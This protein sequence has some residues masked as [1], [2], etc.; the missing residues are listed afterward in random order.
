MDGSLNPWRAVCEAAVRAHSEADAIR[1]WKISHATEDGPRALFDYRFEHTL[2][3]VKL[4]RWLAPLVG[5]DA[6][7]VECSAWLHDIRKRLDDSGGA[8]THAQDA[9]DAVDAILEGT[10]F[11]ASKIPFVKQAI[12]HHVGLG[13]SHRLEPIETA[14]LWDADKLSKIG[15]ASLVHFACISGGF[16][17]VD[18]AQILE[19]GDR[20]L[21]FARGIV[22]SLNTAIARKEGEHRFHFLIHH[23][24]QLR[25]E[26][27]DP[28][29]ESRP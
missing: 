23:Y 14:C 25:R 5:A 26:W 27:H 7:I 11:P 29:Q 1:F 6:E 21:A 12:L 2:G 17:P 16:G 4:A 19:R 22:D 20:W 18:T 3:V 28:M 13:L 9:A 15:A 8:D 10:D 24:A